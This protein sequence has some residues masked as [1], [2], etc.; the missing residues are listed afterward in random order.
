MVMVV[1]MIV[2]DGGGYDNN[3]DSG[4]RKG[5]SSMPARD[6]LIY[7]IIWVGDSVS[8]GFIVDVMPKW[9]ILGRSW[10]LFILR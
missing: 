4:V 7:G 6:F 5:A 2:T 1:M 10:R 3:S 8:C 9:F